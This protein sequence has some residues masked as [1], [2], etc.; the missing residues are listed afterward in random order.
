VQDVERIRDFFQR[1]VYIGK[2]EESEGAESRRMLKQQSRL[3][4]V[5]GAGY[6]SQSMQILQDHP[7]RQRGYGCPDFPTIHR[8]QLRFDIRNSYRQRIVRIL[9]RH[10]MMVYVNAPIFW[11][12][13]AHSL[14][15]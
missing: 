10:D 7:R 5:A 12:I 3:E 11:C 15:A 14:A 13:L 9:R 4:L 6:I 2:R 8:P 1:A